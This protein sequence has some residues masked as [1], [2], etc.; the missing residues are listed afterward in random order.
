MKR[1]FGAKGSEQ[2]IVVARTRLAGYTGVAQSMPSVPV[3]DVSV[4]GASLPP[5]L[6]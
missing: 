2:C 1:T 5:R 4:H 6:S 3:I